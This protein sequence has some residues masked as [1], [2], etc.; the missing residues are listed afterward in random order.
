MGRSRCHFSH[1]NAKA[2]FMVLCNEMMLV[3]QL[4]EVFFLYLVTA[5][6]VMTVKKG[7]A[8]EGTNTKNPKE[9]KK[10]K[11]PAV[12]LLLNRKTLKLPLRNRLV[13]FL[14]TCIYISAR[15]RLL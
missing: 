6:V 9:A 10:E 3:M 15:N 7:I 1:M 14:S 13:W 5:D 11:K 4:F 8:I 12:N 2:V